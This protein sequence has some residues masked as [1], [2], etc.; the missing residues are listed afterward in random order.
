MS[1]AIDSPPSIAKLIIRSKGL[2]TTKK[3]GQPAK[4]F[5]ANKC[6]KKT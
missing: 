2:T 5:S 3:Y 6:A 1:P 4:P